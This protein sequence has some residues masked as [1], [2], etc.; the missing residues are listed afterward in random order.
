MQST[1]EQ[2]KWDLFREKLAEISDNCR[3]ILQMFFNKMSSRDIME[4]LDYASE[5]TVRQRVFKCKTQLIKRIQQDS[6]YEELKD[7]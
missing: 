7:L 3:T 2:E 5:T 1:L 6:R 4:E